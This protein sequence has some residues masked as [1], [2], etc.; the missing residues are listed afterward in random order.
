MIDIDKL[1]VA[2]FWGR[3]AKTDDGCWT[4][5]ASRTTAGYG[6]LRSHNRYDY[7]HRVAYR[8]CRKCGYIRLKGYREQKRVNRE[9]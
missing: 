1:D 8:H 7:A 4:W 6:N 9:S 2:K 5:T 3:V